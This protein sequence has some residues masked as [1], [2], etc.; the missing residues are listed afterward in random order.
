MKAFL[1][2]FVLGAPSAIAQAHI[3]DEHTSNLKCDGVTNDHDA[4]QG[5]FDAALISN[6]AVQLPPG[7]CRTSTITFYGQSFFGAGKQLTVI[8]GMPGQDV[9]ATPDSHVSLRPYAHIHDLTIQP[10][11]TVN[12]ASNAVGGNNTFPNRIFGTSGGLIPL[13][14]PP[15]PGPL[16]FDP[17]IEGNC[18]GTIAAGADVLSIPC[19]NL[20]QIPA[21]YFRGVGVKV[22]MFS[23]TLA[24]V[25]D[26]SHITLA[27]RAPSTFTNTIVSIAN[28]FQPPWYCGNAGIAI[29]ASDGANAP[30]NLN[31]WVF[32]N[33]LIEVAKVDNGTYTCG[34]FIQAPPNDIAFINVDTTVG[35]AG[36]IEALPAVN[37]RRLFAWTPDT[38]I[39]TN[40]NIK[41]STIPMT[42]VNGTHR[43][44]NGLNIYGGNHPYS[45]G[46]FQFCVNLGGGCYPTATFIQYYN[47][48]WT[49]NTGELARFSGTDVFLGGNLGQ[50]NGNSYV[51]FQLTKSTIDAQVSV[52]FK[53][54]NSDN[55]SPHLAGFV[56]QIP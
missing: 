43:I 23:T 48:C 12:A 32:E 52:K 7:T 4:L 53:N 46:L 14:Q 42:W 50:C 3:G 11:A 33:V 29:P 49:P 19:A 38:S 28:P 15:A 1:I 30:T 8:K 51:N 41:F 27:A 16:V 17:A 2:L 37:S 24:K 6:T 40:V 22:G 20:R 35:Y 10:D 21:S 44:A 9:F 13:A 36:I 47:E 5:L 18:G 39:Y 26:D 25:V 56:Q 34:L 31:G 45:L 55:Y 54:P